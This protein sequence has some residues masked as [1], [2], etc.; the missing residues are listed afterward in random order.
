MYTIKNI[1]LIFQVI[2]DCLDEEAERRNLFTSKREALKLF[3]NMRNTDSTS[4]SVK[5]K[6]DIETKKYLIDLF[7][8]G[9]SLSRI[10]DP[11]EVASLDSPNEVLSSVVQVTSP[12]L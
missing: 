12:S 5:M 7:T 1:D 3:L 4:I 8:T 11:I 2:Q 10:Q 9:Q 6:S